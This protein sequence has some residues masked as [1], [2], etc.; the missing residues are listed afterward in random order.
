MSNESEEA[1]SRAVEGGGAFFFVLFRS[2]SF[3]LSYLD[4]AAATHALKI[5]LPHTTA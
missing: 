1:E 2:S 3:M 4:S 5:R